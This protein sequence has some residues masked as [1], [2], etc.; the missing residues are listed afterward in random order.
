MRGKST[1]VLAVVCGGLTDMPGAM[2]GQIYGEATIDGAS[3]Y[4]YRIAVEDRGEPGTS[5]TY[6]IILSNGYDSGRHT[7]DGGNI[8]IHKQ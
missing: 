8:Q 7:L 1:S 3:S 5:D 4:T 2:Q 6:W